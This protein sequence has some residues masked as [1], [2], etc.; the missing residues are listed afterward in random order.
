MPA[1]RRRV[2]YRVVWKGYAGI[3]ADESAGKARAATFRA[4][5]DVYHRR[6]VRFQDITVRRAPEWDQ[7]AAADRTGHSWDETILAKMEQAPNA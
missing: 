1:D 4:L 7:W 6:D 5:L 2:A 3:R